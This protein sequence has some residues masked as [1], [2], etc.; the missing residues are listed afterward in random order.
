MS[1]R[2]KGAEIRRSGERCGRHC[3]APTNGAVREQSAGAPRAAAR[4]RPGAP[5]LALNVYTPPLTLGL[6]R[7]AFPF[8]PLVCNILCR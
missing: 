8:F 5:S 7:V 2:G 1:G 6:E 4:S 3:N